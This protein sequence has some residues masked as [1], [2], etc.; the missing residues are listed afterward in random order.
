MRSTPHAIT[1][2]EVM[3]LIVASLKPYRYTADYHGAR[4]TMSSL[5]KR[6]LMSSMSSV[7]LLV[8]VRGCRVQKMTISLTWRERRVARE[9]L[10][11]DEDPRDDDS[12]HVLA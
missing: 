5:V 8:G 7:K 9:D 1:L 11:V 6:P 10:I 3:T 4:M 12:D 2:I